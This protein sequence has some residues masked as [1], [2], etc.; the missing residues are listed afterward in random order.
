MVV[1]YR[2]NGKPKWSGEVK[3]Y[4]E[5]G[6]PRSLINIENDNRHG[7]YK[8]WDRQGVLVSE[9]DYTHGKINA[10]DVRV[11]TGYRPTLQK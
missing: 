5:D 11:M 3:S 8:H 1:E 10:A 2:K 9:W 7:L 6:M 4:Y